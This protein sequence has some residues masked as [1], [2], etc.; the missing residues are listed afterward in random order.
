MKHAVSP[1]LA[2]RPAPWKFAL[3]L[4]LVYISWGTTYLA[5]EEGVKTLPP[6]LFAGTR[7]ALAGLT[8]L[9]FL[10]LS[11]GTVRLS[12]RDAVLTCLSGGLMFVGGN[13]MLTFAEK[14]VPS[15]IAAVLAA[16]IPLWMALLEAVFPRG[17]RLT[18]R[19]WLGLL[20]GLAGVALLLSEK[21]LRQPA[22]VFADAGPFLVLG[23][24]TAWSLGS[25]LYRHGG[26]RAPHL[27]AA[28]Y[29]ML[30]GGGGMAVIGLMMGEARGLTPACLTG[31]AVAAFFYLLVV[32]SLIGFIAYNWLLG[33]ASAALAGTYAYVN[34]II[35]LLVGWL[36]AAET[37]SLGVFAGGVVILVGV[38][39]VRLG[40]VRRQRPV[41]ES[42]DAPSARPVAAT[43]LRA[44]SVPARR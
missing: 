44:I 9:A 14:T 31:G 33:H 15:G 26:S 6:A 21:W 2:G 38:A 22:S 42:P 25:F 32:G 3:A 20:I 17:D 13:G 16:T 8:V 43:E 36:L 4:A 39:L 19:G 37:L 12:R 10:A 27:T 34:P 29:Q 18:W 40:G 24:A 30:F 7:V 35:A 5:I 1:H 28:A 11:G 23:S 41:A